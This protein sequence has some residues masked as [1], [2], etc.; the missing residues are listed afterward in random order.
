MAVWKD[1]PGFEGFYKVSD[2]GE[3][4]SLRSGK[5]RKPV[6]NKSNGYLYVI[7]CGNDKKC[8]PVHRIV[9]KAFVPDPDN[10]GHVNHKDENKHNNKASNLEWC[11]KAYNNTYG[12]KISR[13]YKPIIQRDPLTGEE[14]LWESCLFP[15][16]EGIANK[17]NISACCRGLRKH[18][19][20]YEWRYA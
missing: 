18:A 12:T 20:G 17:K 6:P 4:I 9:A 15:E 13:L 2:D 16:L 14:T 8:L 10:L 5:L 19:G 7:L 11:T 1:V 3:I